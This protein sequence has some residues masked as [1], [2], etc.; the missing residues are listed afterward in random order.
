MDIDAIIS[1][2]RLMGSM[3]SWFAQRDYLEVE[4]PTLSADRIPE[5]TIQ[6]FSTRLISEFL[7]EKELYL[8]P[9]PEVFMK[10][11][12]AATHRSIYQ[13]SHCFRNS[14]QI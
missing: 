8:I 1:R 12:I 11:V 5:P 10:K 14:E 13:F 9:S 6:N 7:G 2:S 4:T 3:R